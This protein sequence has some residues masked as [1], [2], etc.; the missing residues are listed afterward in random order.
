MSLLIL[1]ISKLIQLRFLGVHMFWEHYKLCHLTEEAMWPWTERTEQMDKPYVTQ[2]WDLGERWGF[3]LAAALIQLSNQQ[4][5]VDEQESLLYAS[6][7]AD[8]EPPAWVLLICSILWGLQDLNNIVLHTPPCPYGWSCNAS[9]CGDTTPAKRV[10]EDGNRDHDHVSDH[11]EI[12]V[13]IFV[14]TEVKIYRFQL[15]KL[16]NIKIAYILR[17]VYKYTYL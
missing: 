4:P 1:L 13:N 2:C 17:K 3:V 10:D 12:F 5:C 14:G 16:I 7:T 15:R 6:V 8:R 9:N 11:R